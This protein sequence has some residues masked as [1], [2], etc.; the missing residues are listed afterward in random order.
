M[1][2]PLVI[3]A[4]S[5]AEVTLEVRDIPVEALA[6]EDSSRWD[7][8]RWKRVDADGAAQRAALIAERERLQSRLSEIDAI[9][10]AAD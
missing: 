2:R 5:D 10:A 8:L 4:P 9:L 6:A 1:R 7:S 3:S